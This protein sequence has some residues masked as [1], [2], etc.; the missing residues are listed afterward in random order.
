MKKS[1]LIEMFNKWLST[2]PDY[3]TESVESTEK[4]ETTEN[5][6]ETE[7]AGEN[8]TTESVESTETVLSTET[9]T[10]TETV[11]ENGEYKSEE[12]RIYVT[13]SGEYAYR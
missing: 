6:G 1:E 7:T 5:T 9:I 4:V 2:I 10:R 8:E 3:E 13:D 12:K 11:T